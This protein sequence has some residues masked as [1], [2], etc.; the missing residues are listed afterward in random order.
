MLK[1]L[2]PAEESQSNDQFR[3]QVFFQNLCFYEVR[4]RSWVG[5]AAQCGV[6]AGWAEESDHE[7]G[8]RFDEL[9]IFNRANLPT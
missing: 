8:G 3:F 6:V 1:T 7:A 2:S 9:R 5:S 4:P